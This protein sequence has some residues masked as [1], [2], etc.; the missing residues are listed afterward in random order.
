MPSLSSA[1]VFSTGPLVAV[2][3]GHAIAGI[4]TNAAQLDL[5]HVVPIALGRLEDIDDASLRCRIEI[6]DAVPVQPVGTRKNVVEIGVSD[7]RPER[8]DLL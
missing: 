7:Q 2:L 8:A 5:G 3:E 1:P 6:L 4:R